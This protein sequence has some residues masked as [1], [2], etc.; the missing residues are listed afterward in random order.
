MAI[1]ANPLKRRAPQLDPSRLESANKRAAV[2]PE[3]R[4]FS[5]EQLLRKAIPEGNRGSQ[6]LLKKVTVR[7]HDTNY[8]VLTHK[9]GI[10]K[11]AEM[12]GGHKTAHAVRDPRLIALVGKH[13][14]TANVEFGT[15]VA[16]RNAPNIPRL[17]ECF[18][19]PDRKFAL[20]MN[21]MGQNLNE[22]F[23]APGV[24]ASLK[25]IRQ[26]AKKL[27]EALACMHSLRILHG[28]VKPENCSEDGLFDFGLSTQIGATQ[29][30]QTL[31]SLSYRPPETMF[32][33]GTTLKS[34]LWALGCLLYEL[35]THRQLIFMEVRKGATDAEKKTRYAAVMDRRLNIPFTEFV[36]GQ[37]P[38]FSVPMEPWV[39]ELASI[40][41]DAYFGKGEL[42]RDLLSK[43]L[44]VDK[45][46][47]ISAS[48]A[49]KHPFFKKKKPMNQEH[50]TPP[51]SRGPSFSDQQHKKMVI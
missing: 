25:T 19:I 8:R 7:I 35:A 49:L 33:W 48:D 34:D 46:A 2:K 38:L 1:Q 23:I 14:W 39:Y 27:L 37:A 47:R 5:P 40:R 4:Q 10:K 41:P 16:L 36:T 6:S 43:M 32:K 45:G 24:N 28:D 21:N 44:L 3:E 13:A 18:F 9:Y 30:Y 29:D 42:F 26:I 31:Y 51:L 12:S 20:V 22:K 15:L 50:I 17:R 11:E